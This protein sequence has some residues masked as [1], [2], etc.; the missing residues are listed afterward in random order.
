MLRVSQVPQLGG[1]EEAVIP[2]RPGGQGPA[3]SRRCLGAGSPS[4]PAAPSLS[5]G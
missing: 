4:L 3:H 1:S 5:S 2:C